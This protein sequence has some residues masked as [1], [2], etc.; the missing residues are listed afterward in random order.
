MKGKIQ[1]RVINLLLC[2][3][4]ICVTAS[5]VFAVTGDE[6]S[7]KEETREV[8]DWSVT[9][10]DGYKFIASNEKETVQSLDVDMIRQV[11]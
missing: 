7:S 11:C 4:M 3:C 10:K 5:N 8:I 1:Q 6:P 9:N 2:L